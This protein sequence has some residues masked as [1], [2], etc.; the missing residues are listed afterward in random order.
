[1][2]S[3]PVPKVPTRIYAG[4]AGPRGRL[5]PFGNEPNDG[6]LTVKETEIPGIPIVHVRALHTF[7]MNA[8]IVADDI[9][10]HALTLNPHPGTRGRSA[11]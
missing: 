9:V 4:T 1:M 5:S 2:S 8:R 10:A 11:V 3:L 6:I 7:I